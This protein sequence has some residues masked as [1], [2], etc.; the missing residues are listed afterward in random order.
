MEGTISGDVRRFIRSCLPLNSV[1]ESTS[2]AG[3]DTASPTTMAINATSRLRRKPLKNWG[4]TNILEYHWK[5]YPVGGSASSG[6]VK[7]LS[8]ATRNKGNEMK[9]KPS[10]TQ[11]FSTTSARF[12][13]LLLTAM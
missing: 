1:R 13:F 3:M 6:S 4:S 11:A 7:K 8:Q 2:A 5:L 10:N 9:T 12:R